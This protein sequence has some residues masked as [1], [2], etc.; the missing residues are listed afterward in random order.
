[1]DIRTEGAFPAGKPL[2]LFEQPGFRRGGPIPNWDVRPNGKGFIMV[3]LNQRIFPPV[4]EMMVIQNWFEE[5]K[6]LC[7]VGK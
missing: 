7:S 2:L 3:K 6:R 5:L 1:V 4:T